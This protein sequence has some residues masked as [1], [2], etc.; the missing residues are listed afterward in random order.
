VTIRAIMVDVDGVLIVHPDARGWSRNLERDLGLSPSRLQAAFFKPHWDDVM[1]GRAP[2]RE[3]LGPVL[4]D[5]APHLSCDALIAYWF[6]EDAHVNAALLT[7]LAEIR[8][9]GTE[10]HLATVQEHERAR[11]LWEALDFRSRFDGFHYAAE[12]GCSKP[13]AAFYRSI[14]A[15]T[16][17][18]PGELF[19][20]DDL[21][22]NVDGATASG[23]GAAL[24]TGKDKVR[25]LVPGLMR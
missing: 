10:V 14:E 22:K 25:S 19:L 9:G 1:H 17:F 7:E 24:W 3:R 2:L 20:I 8:A 21:A 6:A 5:I 16:G 18:R 11:Y 23:W 13:A 4:Q 12:L 15:R